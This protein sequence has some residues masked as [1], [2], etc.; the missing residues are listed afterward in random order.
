MPVL[1]G[2]NATKL[3]R[4]REAKFNLERLA[5]F[6]LTAFALEEEQMKCQYYG[7]DSHF[8]KPIRKQT[9]FDSLKEFGFLIE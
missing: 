8:A 5:I 6:A 2:F 4:E 3:I 1:D 7:C 9:L